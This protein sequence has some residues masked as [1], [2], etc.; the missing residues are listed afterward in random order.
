MKVTVIYQILLASLL[1]VGCTKVDL[2]DET[3]HPHVV[4]GFSVTY[5]WNELGLSANETPEKLYFV[6]TRI[7]NTR[8]I[9]YQTDKDGNFKVE[10]SKEETAI[11]PDDGNT[12]TSGDGSTTRDNTDITTPDDQSEPQSEYQPD[13]KLPGGEYVMM[14]FTDPAYPMVKKEKKDE[15]G[16][17]VKDMN[18][19]IVMEEVKDTRVELHNLDEF[20]ENDAVHMKE[21]K[22]RHHA[23][24]SVTDI[25]HDTWKDLNPGIEH[26]WEAGRRLIISRCD[27]LE[28]NAG[29]NYEQP[30]NFTS[31]TQHIDINYYL[32]LVEDGEGED[33]QQLKPEDIKYIFVEM[34][35]IVPE[36]SLST[37][38]LNTSSLKRVIVKVPVP[39]TGETITE[40]SGKKCTT[41]KCTASMD[42]F[43]LVGGMDNYAIMGP[44]V[45]C[46]ALS[47]KTGTKEFISNGIANLSR[48]I[49]ELGLTEETGQVNERRRL[50]DSGELTID[51]HLRITPSGAQGGAGSDGVIG[52]D[53]VTNEIHVDI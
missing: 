17:V 3:T 51:V 20:K 32:D 31:L 22:M 2:C 1:L 45:C 29:N 28:L 39:T 38:L 5:N 47:V 7:L 14:A 13:I 46:L 21:V 26:V 40:E 41:L 36:I 50:K 6:A 15:D 53:D 23:L 12:E 16:N 11:T 43:G 30:F 37:G 27:Y 34:S 44:G 4:D 24:E 33:K 52:W 18:D 8:H 42:V 10:K 48:K 19:N 9:V 35:G 25:V 49:K